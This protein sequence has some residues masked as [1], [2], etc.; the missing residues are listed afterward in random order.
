MSETAHQRYERDWVSI[1][2]TRKIRGLD[3]QDS[4]RY[5]RLYVDEDGISAVDVRIPAG[6]RAN[7]ENVGFKGN[8]AA[9][10]VLNVGDPLPAGMVW[11]GPV[12][13]VNSASAVLDGYKINAGV[14]FYGANPTIKN[15]IVI[16]DNQP[17]YG[18]NAR[19]GTLTITDCTVI[20][21]GADQPA[22]VSGEDGPVIATRCDL[23]GFGDGIV[24][25][26]ASQIKQCYIHDLS[27][28]PEEHNDGIQYYGGA[29]LTIEYCYITLLDT[30]G[31]SAGNGQNASISLDITDPPIVNVTVNNNFMY[32]G[33]YFFRMEGDVTGSIITNN[34]FGP[35]VSPAV[36][37]IA[38]LSENVGTWSNN[39]D[40]DGN[41]IPA[42]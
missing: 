34:E 40:S 33:V 29:G 24:C 21:A 14:D 12:L 11:D 32:G 6:L 5:T 3:Q 41:I 35:V 7:T 25:K 2:D 1:L 23:S 4:E 39:I 16:T 22:V 38:V 42:P 15:S 9:L 10:D 20:G 27:L 18:V 19:S 36:N 28:G 8:E 31:S 17:F 37:E 13:R 30:D 26:G